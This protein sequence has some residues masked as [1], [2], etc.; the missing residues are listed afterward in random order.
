MTT[1]SP[2]S[3]TGLIIIISIAILIVGVVLY[4]YRDKLFG[5]NC[6]PNRNGFDKKGNPNPKCQFNDPKINNEPAPSGSGGWISDSSFPIKKGSWGPRVA[7]LQKAI[8]ANQDG[9]FGPK[10]EAA[11]VEKT[12]KREVSNMQEYDAIVNASSI[13]AA[14][15][16]GKKVYAKNQ[17]VKVRSGA[18]VNDGVINN[19]ICELP[20]NYEPA[21]IVINSV[22][23]STDSRYRWYQLQLSNPSNCMNYSKGYVRED[24]VILK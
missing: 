20:V 11:L 2:K 18:Y 21:P 23:G 22:V 3:R 4:I 10:T 1:T 17:T 24:V 19:I 16:I 7:A 9:K 15:A 12:G 6:D 5:V 14:D 8:G 13:P